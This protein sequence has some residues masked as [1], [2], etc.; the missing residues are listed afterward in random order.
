MGTSPEHASDPPTTDRHTPDA[1][2][3]IW[4]TQTLADSPNQEAFQTLQKEKGIAN[5]EA[6]HPTA[7][8]GPSYSVF[9][10]HQ[11]RVSNLS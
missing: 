6:G 1:R 7:G 5:L 4:S 11:K 3:S 8:N 9:G 10:K 2:L